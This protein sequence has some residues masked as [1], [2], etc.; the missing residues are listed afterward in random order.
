MP[1]LL[2]IVLL[3]TNQTQGNQQT[4]IIQFGWSSAGVAVPGLL[5]VVLLLTNKTQGD[6]QTIIV[7]FGCDSYHFVGVFA[8]LPFLSFVAF[9]ALKVQKTEEKYTPPQG[10][11]CNS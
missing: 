6:Q 3:I 8:T 11:Y 2:I 9:L 4:S 5:I 10:P 7:H 1:G